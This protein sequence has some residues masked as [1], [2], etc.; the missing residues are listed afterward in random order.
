MAV[1]LCIL[2]G[3]SFVYSQRLLL[4]QH[5]STT[6]SEI[7]LNKHI[8]IVQRNRKCLQNG[9]IHILA[10]FIYTKSLHNKCETENI[11]WEKKKEIQKQQRLSLHYL[12]C[13]QLFWSCNYQLNAASFCQFF[14]LCVFVFY[15]Y[16][17]ICTVGFHYKSFNKTTS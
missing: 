9:T 1:H 17:T 16:M 5:G 8:G 6:I 2:S 3:H 7:I 14:F 4:S 15:F 11:S 12:N 13:A 10:F